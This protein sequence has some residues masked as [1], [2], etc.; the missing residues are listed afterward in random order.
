MSPL[1]N[2]PIQ[3]DPDAVEAAEEAVRRYCG[4]RIAD[5]ITE[6]VTLDG[7]G[8]LTLFLPSMYVTAIA[9][10]V[11]DGVTLSASAYEWS[12]SGRVDRVGGC[13]PRKPRS[14]VIQMTHGYAVCPPEVREFIKMLATSGAGSAP[15]S[16][17][18]VGQ[19]A[20]TYGSPTPAWSVLDPY[21]RIGVA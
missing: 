6:T 4:W 16:K 19:V 20:V 10:I 8:G 12:T 17:A 5:S 18:Q 7:K 11:A 21:R 14:I 9:S 3:L 15:L 13:W 1:A 2:P